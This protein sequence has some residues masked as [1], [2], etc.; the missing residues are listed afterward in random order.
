[1][2]RTGDRIRFRRPGAEWREGDV[3]LAS[4]NGTAIAL[5]YDGDRVFHTPDGG[6]FIGPLALLIDYERATGEDLFGGQWEI[7]GGGHET[8]DTRIR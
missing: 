6:M 3:V 8:G 2:I 7:E 4:P 1:M 5:E